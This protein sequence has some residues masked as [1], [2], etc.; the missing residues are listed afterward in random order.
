MRDSTYKCDIPDY[1]CDL[2][3]VSRGREETGMGGDREL[4][5]E[6]EGEWGC[7]RLSSRAPLPVS[8]AAT[9]GRHHDPE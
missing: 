9:K 1:K 6:E 8:L 4:R 2:A 7:P 5:Q 3:K